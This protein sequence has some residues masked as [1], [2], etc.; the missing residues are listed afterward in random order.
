M[1]DADLDSLGREDYF[2]TSHNLWLEL[3][4]HG[5]PLTLREWYERQVTFL[6]GHAYFTAVSRSLRESRKQK[7]LVELKRILATL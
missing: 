4:A 7:N 5:T 6:G 1:C 3:A 2:A